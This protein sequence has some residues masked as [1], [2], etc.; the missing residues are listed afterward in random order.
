MRADD[1]YA[2]L[3]GRIRKVTE[4]IAGIASPLIYKGSVD[5]VENLPENPGIGW[6]YNIAQKSIY[7]EAGMNVAWTGTIWDTLGPI[8]DMSLYMTKEDGAKKLDKNQ[9]AENSGMVMGINEDGESVPMFPMGITYDEETRHLKFGSDEKLNL[10]AGIQLDNTLSKTGHAA[11]A[12]KTGERIA[13]L[14]NDLDERIIGIKNYLTN[15]YTNGYYMSTNGTIG[16]NDDNTQ[17]IKYNGVNLGVGTYTIHNFIPM[18][19]IFVNSDGI[20]SRLLG[21]TQENC[22]KLTFTLTEKGSLYVTSLAIY[23]DTYLM[24]DISYGTNEFID[25]YVLGIPYKKIVDAV[26][27][28]YYRTITVKTDG[29]GDFTS[30]HDAINSITDSNKNRRYKIEIYSGEYN[31]I[32]ECGG[33]TFI[34]R[35]DSSTKSDIG[36]FLPNYVDIVG[37]GNVTIYADGEGYVLNDYFVTNFSP[38]NLRYNNKV[39]NITVRA[40]NCR[41]AIHDESGSTSEIDCTNMEHIFKNVTAIHE[42][43][44]S[45]YTWKST[46]PYA[47]GF[48]SGGNFVYEHC[49]FIAYSGNVNAWSCH[50]W[51]GNKYASNFTFKACRFIAQNE[52]SL[53]LSQMSTIKHYVTIDKCYI[54]GG[55]YLGNESGNNYNYFDVMGTCNDDVITRWLTNPP[56]IQNFENAYTRDILSQYDIVGHLTYTRWQKVTD[57]SNAKGIIVNSPLTKYDAIVQTKGYIPVA[58]LTSENVNAGDTICLDDGSIVINGTNVIATYDAYKPSYALLCF[59]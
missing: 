49:N 35:C 37:I 14:K 17:Y 23:K 43:N 22:D 8:V 19:T 26:S 30:I 7:G 4:Q 13:E 31:V 39:E 11:D 10:G 18:F 29:T 51:P 21:N 44:D 41:Y 20:S 56:M 42:G 38:L 12:G 15:D 33:Q 36:L 27:K 6:M 57:G 53:R 54:L 9:G 1:V 52:R 3:N 47:M 5:A 2:V 45:D 46:I 40:K 58:W 28:D 25:G 50:D 48:Q 32:T 16:Q 55:I 59:E 24:D 34:D